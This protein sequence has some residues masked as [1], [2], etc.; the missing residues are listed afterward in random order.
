MF[1]AAD[2]GLTPQD[3]DRI[4]QAESMELSEK[5]GML[6]IRITAADGNIQVLSLYLRSG[7][8]VLP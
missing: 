8:E 4:L 1:A 6:E 5:D 2:S 3:G 7:K